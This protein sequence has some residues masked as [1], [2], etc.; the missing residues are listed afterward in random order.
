MAVRGIRKLTKFL[1][2]RIFGSLFMGY[3]VPYGVLV[4]SHLAVGAGWLSGPRLKFSADGFWFTFFIVTLSYYLF[5]PISYLILT[6]SETAEA[7]A[8]R[9][10]DHLFL[11]LWA[12][13]E[14]RRRGHDVVFTE[15]VAEE[16]L[17]DP[18]EVEDCLKQLYQERRLDWTPEDGYRPAAP[19]PVG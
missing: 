19:A 11:V 10:T 9:N 5:F 3:T 16:A 13:E 14:L 12:V 15:H 2:N 1:D 4:L 17:L 8:Q 6:M 18:E 7:A